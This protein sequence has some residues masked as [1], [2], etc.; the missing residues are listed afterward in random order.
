MTD[1]RLEPA[2]IRAVVAAWAGQPQPGPDRFIPRDEQDRPAQ[3][4]VQGSQDGQPRGARQ[5]LSRKYSPGFQGSQQGLVG[6]QGADLV[7]E[8]FH[9]W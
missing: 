4:R 5:G 6:R 3:V 9:L 8:G 1:A 2:A 7:E